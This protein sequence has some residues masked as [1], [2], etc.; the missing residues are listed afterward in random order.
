M[1]LFARGWPLEERAA[2]LL[3][4]AAAFSLRSKWGSERPNALN[5]PIRSTSRRVSPSQSRARLPKTSHIDPLAVPRFFYLDA[6]HCRLCGGWLSISVSAAPDDTIQEPIG[7]RPWSRPR[8]PLLLGP[9]AFAGAVAFG[10][11]AESGLG[12]PGGVIL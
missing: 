6:A 4:A 1:Q 5:P 3:G 7:I 11:A 12:D 9:D 8:P 10:G 2:N